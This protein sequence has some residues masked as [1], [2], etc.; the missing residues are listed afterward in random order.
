MA[1][2]HELQNRIGGVRDTM[3]ITN[4]MY[5]ISNTKM[6][7]AKRVWDETKPYYVTLMRNLKMIVS[8]MPEMEHPYFDMR[9]EKHPE[10]RVTGYIVITGDKGLAGAY[11]QNIYKLMDKLLA[12]TPNYRLF[13]I[14]QMGM[15]YFM[16]QQLPIEK[17]FLYTAQNP[18]LHRARHIGIEIFE[19]FKQGQLDDVS[20]VYTRMFSSTNMQAIVRPILPLNKETLHA[21]ISK[22]E[23]E[24]TLYPTAED[25]IEMIVPN[26]VV[27]TVYGAMVESYCCEQNAR[28]QAM[29]NATDSAREILSDL[30]LQYNR[31]RQ[32]NITQEITEI[33]GGAKAQK[34]R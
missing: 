27:G 14:G 7:Q 8:R 26:C 3:K 18:S 19:Q 24:F 2:I 31:I 5:M 30:E 6:K 15:H 10:E 32:A 4:A 28:V 22:K 1:S 20:I 17:D 21:E 16:N 12:E 29:K 25:V 9:K 23:R 34:G 11:H 13:V 33:I